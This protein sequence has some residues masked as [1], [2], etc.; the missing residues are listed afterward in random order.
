MLG[1]YWGQ[2]AEEAIR[3]V[4]GAGGEEQSSGRAG[5]AVVTEG[6]GPDAVNKDEG[7]VWLE[8]EA[9][10]FLGEA[11]EGGDP[12][13]TEITHENGVAELAEVARSPDDSPG[14]VEP[15]A[16]LEAALEFT[17]GAEDID[18]TEAVAT[19]G[20][21][22][23]CILL[24]VSDEEAAADVL[25][26]EGR[27]ANGDAIVIE[28]FFAEIYPLEIG[29]VDFDA[30]GAEVGDVK[31]PFAIDFAGSHSL[32]DCTVRR[33]LIRVV[34][35]QNGVWRRRLTA[36]NKVYGGIPAGDGAVFG[37]KDKDGRFAGG[38]A[39]IEEEISR[40]AIEYNAG[41]SGWR[42]GSGESR[43]RDNDEVAGAAVGF[44][45]DVDRVSVAVVQS[46]GTGIVISNP[47]RAASRGAGESPG[48]FQVGV[49]V[50]GHAGYVG[51]E[52]RLGVVL[53]EREVGS[54]EVCKCKGSKQLGT[55]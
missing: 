54:G 25:D 30:A 10:E 34:Y 28:G 26:I 49:G 15:V 7:I 38:R 22:A 23:S 18:E 29:V 13:A 52:I 33:A 48:I 35:F 19:D 36:G 12:A 51:D 46:G 17:G 16:V 37:G 1:D 43:G 3:F 9:D 42:A 32:V 5:G 45:E 39:F 21:V 44:D 27:E 8:D 40:A 6:Q 2:C 31:E 53:R 55:L 20:I 4:V 11:V 41:G 24:S 14:R 47:P 50:G